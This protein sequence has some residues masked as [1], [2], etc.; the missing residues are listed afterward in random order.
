MDLVDAVGTDDSGIPDGAGGPLAARM[1]PRTLDEVVG[2]D[3]L[4]AEG[5][6]LRRLVEAQGGAPSSVFL[7]GPP[8]TGKTTFAY[9]VARAGGRHFEEVSAV[10]AGVKDLRAYL[11]QA[12]S[13]GAPRALPA[14]R[15][16]VDLHRNEIAERL[17]ETGLEVSVGVGHSSFE[18]DLV[19]GASGRAEESGRGALPERFARNAQA[20]RPGVAVLLDGPGWDRRKSVMDRDLLPVDVLG[21]MGWERVERVW[22][23]EW[24]ADPDAVVTRL[25][26]AAGGPPPQEP[27]AQEPEEPASS[28]EPGQPEEPTSSDAEAGAVTALPRQA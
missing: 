28:E 5:S 16:A 4:L 26:E 25:V 6:P 19:L 18:I 11:E 7:W 3:H 22:M 23:P 12:R 27:S 9:L 17:R 8:G 24:V 20:A 21:T 13:G 14:S 10:S 2:Q 1:R 15:S